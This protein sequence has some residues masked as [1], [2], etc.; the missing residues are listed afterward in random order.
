LHYASRG[1]P[2]QPDE[3]RQLDH[4]ARAVLALFSAAETVT[5]R[6]IAAVLGLSPRMAR[7]LARQWVSAGWLVVADPSNRARCYALSASY[8]QLAGPLSAMT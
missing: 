5:T 3:L 2:A 1:A 8:R 4:R 6:Q 7:V